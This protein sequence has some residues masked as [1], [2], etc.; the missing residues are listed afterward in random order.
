[1]SII[2]D[3]FDFQGY[4]WESKGNSDVLD[5]SSLNLIEAFYGEEKGDLLP[6]PKASGVRLRLGEVSLWP[7]ISGHGKSLVTTQVAFNFAK[8]GHKVAIASLEMRPVATMARMARM[9]AGTSRPA[10]TWLK[11]F[12]KWA[13]GKVYLMGSQGIIQPSRVIDFAAYCAKK[14][15][16]RHIFVDNLTKVVRGEDDHNGQKSFVDD[17]CTVARDRDVHIHLVVHTRKTESEHQ[18]PDKFDVRGS[19]SIVDQADNVILVWRHK[20]KEEVLADK[21]IDPAKKQDWESRPDT[22]L[23]VA[24]QRNGDYEGKVGL[25][26]HRESMWFNE[27]PF[28]KHPLPEIFDVPKPKLEKTIPF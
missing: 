5:T 25:H 28:A 16:C 12:V 1:V 24:K 27:A 17:L 2:A 6:W 23:I 20:K 15:G 13:E 21:K 8:Q 18:M 14:L 4:Q 3:S 7:G 11:E 26:V 9:V 19:S 22:V 10:E